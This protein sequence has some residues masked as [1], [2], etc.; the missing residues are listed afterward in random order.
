VTSPHALGAW[1]LDLENQRITVQPGVVNYSGV[2]RAV[3]G[4]GFYYAPIP[5]AQVVCQHRRAQR[6][7]RTPAG[8][9]LPQK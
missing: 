2:T 7:L 4:E 6:A 8:V 1:H 9:P 5:P 3:S